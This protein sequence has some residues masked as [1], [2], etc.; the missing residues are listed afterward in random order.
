MPN[1]VVKY[2]VTSRA[3]VKIVVKEAQSMTVAR[4]IRYNGFGV[5]EFGN[6]D[7]EG[8]PICGTFVAMIRKPRCG[9]RDVA[10]VEMVVQVRGQA[11]ALWTIS[12][13]WGPLLNDLLASY[14]RSERQCGMH[15]G[16]HNRIAAVGCVERGAS[17]KFALSGRPVVDVA[18]SSS[19]PIG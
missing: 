8:A 7:S 13:R 16:E 6:S 18:R 10:S 4:V 9:F 19:W 12:D 3:T 5:L 11:G 17:K 15:M 1:L 2:L 14:A